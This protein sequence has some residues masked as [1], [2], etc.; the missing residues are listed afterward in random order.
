MDIGANCDWERRDVLAMRVPMEHQPLLSGFKASQIEV[1]VSPDPD[2][3]P[4]CLGMVGVGL[5]TGV[6]CWSLLLECSSLTL[7][8]GPLSCW[9]TCAYQVA[10]GALRPWQQLPVP[11]LAV[12]VLLSLSTLSP[13]RQ[14]PHL[15]LFPSLTV[16][17]RPCQREVVA[18]FIAQFFS[19]AFLPHV[20]MLHL[21]Q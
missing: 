7:L 14:E 9:C 20:G 10:E 11:H 16:V 4:M 15:M 19:L 2:L 8:T 17:C 5:G 21:E 13:E 6:T 3:A 12:A 18:L 1:A